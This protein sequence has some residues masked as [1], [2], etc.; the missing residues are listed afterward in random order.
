MSLLISALSGNLQPP[1]AY[2]FSSRTV[3]MDGDNFVPRELP[4]VAKMKNEQK[5]IKTSL[6]DR[7]MA[8]LTEFPGSTVDQIAEDFGTIPN[9]V[10]CAIHR[11]REQDKIRRE[12][13]DGP[14]TGGRGKYYYWVKR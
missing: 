3:R 9:N 11:L 5:R 6:Q 2:L 4:S 1:D 14:K 13:G 12:L 8:F 7:V 10:Q